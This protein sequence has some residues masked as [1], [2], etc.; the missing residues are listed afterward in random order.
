MNP[1]EQIDNKIKN[2]DGWCKPMMEE[3]RRV[4]NSVDPELKED[5]KWNTAVWTKN[6]LVCAIGAF[7]D[8]VK[9]N[10][11]KGQE[12]ADPD[13]LFNTTTDAKAMRSI[14]FFEGDKIDE[15][16]LQRLIRSA[17]ELNT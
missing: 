16:A 10:F 5:W 9:I 12:L 13:K 11:F 15:K 1:S 17:I 8:H 6:G 2:L 4:I 3:L 7:K 14:D